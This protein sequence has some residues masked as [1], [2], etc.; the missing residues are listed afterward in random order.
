MTNDKCSINDM[1]K[2]F[3][4][5]VSEITESWLP[6]NGKGT[7][8]YAMPESKILKLISITCYF[9]FQCFGGFHN[10]VPS[11]GCTVGTSILIQG[12]KN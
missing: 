4:N 6:E 8:H 12:F 2:D 3:I 11:I 10:L 5:S 1:D 7:T 9:F